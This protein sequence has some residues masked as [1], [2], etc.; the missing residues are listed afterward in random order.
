M[1]L[2]EKNTLFESLTNKLDVY[3][4]LR[5]LLYTALFS[6]E[7]ISYNPYNDMIGIASMFGFVKNNQGVMVIANRIFETCL[8]NLF[9]SEDEVNSRIY[10]AGSMDKN[11]FIQNGNLNMDLII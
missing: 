3:P 7:R 4:K 1:I 8:Y 11:Q 9:L 6:G 10:A 2:S 5:E